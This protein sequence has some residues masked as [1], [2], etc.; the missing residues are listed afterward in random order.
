MTG[1]YMG[2]RQITT[3]IGLQTIWEFKGDTENFGIYGFTNLNRAM[4][5]VKPHTLCRI[6]YMGT[7]NL[8]TKFGMKDVHQVK[9]EIDKRSEE[10]E[11]PVIEE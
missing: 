9:V 11:P 2:N 4:E 1:T 3:K 7:K 5:R 10:E 6:T 8:Q